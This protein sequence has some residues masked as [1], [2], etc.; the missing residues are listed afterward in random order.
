MTEAII[1]YRY[2]RDVLCGRCITTALPTGEGQTFDGWADATGTMGA[3][4]FLQGIADAFGI[5]RE[6]FSNANEFPVAM[7]PLDF[8]EG[9]PACDRCGEILL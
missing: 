7:A 9:I 2:R 4:E 3:E 1:G 5:N 6:T 8:I